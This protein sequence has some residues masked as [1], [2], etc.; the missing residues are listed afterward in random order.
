MLK[1]ALFLLVLVLLRQ[2]MI[3]ALFLLAEECSFHLGSYRGTLLL[4]RLIW[5]LGPDAGMRRS[6]RQLTVHAREAL[7]ET[8]RAIQGARRLADE[9]RAVGSWELANTAINTFINAGLYREALEVEQLWPRGKAQA[10]EEE[11]GESEALAQLNL[12]EALYNLGDWKAAGE[13][14]HR[15]EEAA[16]EV[17]ILR[18]GI[19]LQRAWIQANTGWGANALACLEQVEREDLP[20]VYW[21]E[22]TFTHAAAL[23]A[24]RRYDEAEQQARAGLELARRAASTRNGL[25]LLGRISLEAG[26]LEAALRHFEVGAA[27]PYKGQGGSGLLA[28]GDCL[29]RLGQ[30]EQARE[31]W[32][33]VLERDPQSGAARKAIS[34]LGA[35]SDPG[36]LVLGG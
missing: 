28:W 17:P 13:R 9:A 32:R 30:S 35:T 22:V 12:C 24:L 14:L 31:A 25:F 33:L 4:T 19:L 18:N 23:L 7:G 21:S 5:L 8:A 34:R 10:L 26:R 27:H 6:L 1:L 20:R 11:L 29:D 2:V 36:G 3:G 15:L 16:G